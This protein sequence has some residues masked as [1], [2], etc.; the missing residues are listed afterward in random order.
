MTMPSPPRRPERSWW[1]GNG[2]ATLLV[3]VVLVLAAGAVLHGVGAPGAGNLLWAGSGAAG[4]G[5]S[6]WMTLESLRHGR[7]GV[8]LIAVLALVGAVAVG[9]YLAAGVIAVMVESGRALE[10]GA[11]GRAPRDLGALLARAPRFARR[12]GD[13]GLETI[14]VE[15]I[16]MGDRL[17]AG[18][19]EMLPADGVLLTAA[20]LDESVLT[21]ES[22]P[23][24]R[25]AGDP[26]RSGVVNAGAP[27]EMRATA[28]AA[29]STYAGVIRLVADA[30]A[31]QAP[32]VRL[33]DR[34]ALWFLGVSVAAS[35][36][37]WALAGPARAVAVLVVA[38]PCPLILA[39]PI[40]LVAGLSQAARR[41]VIIKGGA[42]LERLARCTTVLIDKTGTLTGGH[43]TLSDVVTA[44]AVS[45]PELLTLAASLDQLSPHV[46]AHAV[47]ASARGRGCELTVP[48]AVREVPGAGIEGIVAGRPVAVGKAD[49][50]GMAGSPRWAGR[51][52]RRAR[53]DGSST[54]FVGVDDHPAGVL[55]FDDP[56]RPDAARTIRGLRVSGIDRVVM[57]TGDRIEVADAIGAVLGVDEV[58]ADR[59]P[60][61]KLDAVRIERRRAPT[62]MVGDGVNDAPAPA[63]AGR[64]RATGCRRRHAA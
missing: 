62:L 58:L 22:L 30:G 16:R 25:G 38:T 11:A 60:E 31:S 15:D 46:L 2:A 64:G 44:G 3:A 35:G 47:V 37:A 4:A 1:A 24:E 49:W 21:G 14:P 34:Y 20:V 51:A 29:A 55:L 19:G 5:Y 32:F 18:T 54:V 48:E 8:D 56:V 23:A 45:A 57:V 41:G 39:A 53:L 40:A 6:L 33:A 63:P 17:V 10:S 28:T 59:S 9:E 42:V 27:V 50:V 12:V 26:V 52:R 36:T 13:D 61:E 43:P 7:L